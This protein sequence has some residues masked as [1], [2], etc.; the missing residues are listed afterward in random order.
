MVSEE[1]VVLLAVGGASTVLPFGFLGRVAVVRLEGGDSEAG[2]ELALGRNF[3]LGFGGDFL[4][5]LSC[6][7][8]VE[9]VPFGTSLGH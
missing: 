9:A 2:C 1:V 4:T 8:L 3:L 6:T 7:S 5:S